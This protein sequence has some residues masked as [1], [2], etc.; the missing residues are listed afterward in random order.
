[1]HPGVKLE[2]GKNGVVKVYFTVDETESG[3]GYFN[4]SCFHLP[5]GKKLGIARESMKRLWENFSK[6]GSTRER[7]LCG[8]AAS[9][10]AS[11][12]AAAA[13]AGAWS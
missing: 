5:H 3:K 1:M 10:V 9:S 4:V 8:S 11:A 6:I 2:K 7:F 13:S 12:A